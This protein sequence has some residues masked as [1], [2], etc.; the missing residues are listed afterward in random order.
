VLPE[1][2][3]IVPMLLFPCTYIAFTCRT[4]NLYGAEISLELINLINYRQRSNL[5]FVS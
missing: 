2:V 4:V 1:S 5:T 3:L